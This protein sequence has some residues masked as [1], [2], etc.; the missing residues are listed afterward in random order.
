MKLTEQ[1]YK[2]LVTDLSNALS[3]SFCYG[4]KYWKNINGFEDPTIV[5]E[6]KDAKEARCRM[7]DRICRKLCTAIYND[8]P[9]Q[10]KREEVMA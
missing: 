1:D 10:Y 3:L 9:I 4:V 8:E 6:V 2:E 5:V 7:F